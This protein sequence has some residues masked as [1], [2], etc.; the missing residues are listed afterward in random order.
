VCR[1]AQRSPKIKAYR[2][3]ITV[4]AL[5]LVVAVAL[6]AS[7]GTY[8]VDPVNGNDAN[9]GLSTEEA[10]ATITYA[11]LHADN[12]S[13][14]YCREGVDPSSYGAVSITR[15]STA[16]NGDTPDAN[17]DYIHFYPYEDEEPN[18]ISLTFGGLPA[19]TNYDRYIDVNGI[20]VYPG[21]G[22]VG[23]HIYHGGYIQFRNGAVH[24]TLEYCE[25]GG[26]EATYWQTNSTLMGIAF[27]KS[28]YSMAHNILI[29]TVEVN[30][31]GTN[32][33]TTYG[34][35]GGPIVVQN[36]HV[37]HIGGSGVRLANARTAGATGY[38]DVIGCEINHQLCVV[39]S[40]LSEYNHGTGITLRYGYGRALRNTIHAFGNTSAIT[41][42]RTGA[43]DMVVENNLCY[44]CAQM[45]RV[46]ILDYIGNNCKFNYNT[47][48][49]ARWMNA[50]GSG[51]TYGEGATSYCYWYQAAVTCT[52]AAA[53]DKS[54]LEF[55]GNLLVGYGGGLDTTPP[56]GACTGNIFYSY[57]STSW[58]DQAWMNAN[59]P[60]NTVYTNGWNDP[61]DVFEP[62]TAFF[63]GSED[64][65]TYSYQRTYRAP[66]ECSIE[67][68]VQRNYHGVDLGGAYDLKDDAPAIGY[69]PSAYSPATDLLGRARHTW[70]PDAGC[71]EN[72]TPR[73]PAKAANPFP[74]SGATGR[75][76]ASTLA[77]SNGGGA[78][79]YDVYIQVDEGELTLVSDGQ[80]AT[81]YAYTAP[82]SGLTISWRI[83]AV[84]SG[85]SGELVTTGDVWT[86]DIEDYPL[87][88]PI[89]SK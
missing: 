73:S 81:T 83:D 20:K 17:E 63:V 57:L 60:G 64:F 40:D 2:S 76:K 1:I 35:W 77:W 23:V 58:R 85:G 50:D 62:N 19:T 14:I 33:I 65:N 5:W 38:F 69:G 36:C 6:E 4:A 86:Y 26:C 39:V 89:F 9:D 28:G 18:F 24:G 10:W 66:T 52:I 25:I 11:E 42:Y 34:A 70:N 22:A 74:A 84:I 61:C 12:G 72:Q 13:I 51:L 80:A 67:D 43:S 31:I 30:D 53:T 71:Y 44:D 21:A 16:R 48:L 55:C 47:I 29:D 88:C 41:I 27:G 49:G 7:A 8:Y 45:S 79:S 32:G 15:A 78:T 3:Q 56:L 75:P 37:H 59:L 54:T 82:S 68:G 87:L 46:C